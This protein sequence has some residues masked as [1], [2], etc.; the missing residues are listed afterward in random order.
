LKYLPRSTARRSL[1][2]AGMQVKQAFLSKL[3]VSAFPRD[4]ARTLMLI[5]QLTFLPVVPAYLHFY[6]NDAG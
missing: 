1:Q 2:I 6:R 5:Q 4:Q 3:S